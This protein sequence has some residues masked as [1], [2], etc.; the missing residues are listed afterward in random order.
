MP[1]E[2]SDVYT[3]A[4]AGGKNLHILQRH[5]EPP[6][7]VILTVSDIFSLLCVVPYDM[8]NKSPSKVIL[9]YSLASSGAP[10]HPMAGVTDEDF[11]APNWGRATRVDAHLP[12][13]DESFLTDRQ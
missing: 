4:Q 13:V 9:R 8:T 2:T 3:G 12:T 10:V 5:F 7:A 1:K 11:F 6:Y